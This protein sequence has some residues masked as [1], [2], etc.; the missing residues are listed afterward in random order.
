MTKREARAQRRAVRRRVRTVV[1]IILM[2]MMCM[3]ASYID[4]HYTKEATIIHTTNSH[5]VV[6]AIDEQGNEWEFCA[7]NVFVGQTIEMKMF[8]NNTTTIYDDEVV[9]IKVVAEVK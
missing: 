2:I 5:H 3:L 1:I 9:D 6:V 4:T 7:D 8:T